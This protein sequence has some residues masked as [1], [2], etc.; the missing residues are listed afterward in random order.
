MDDAFWVLIAFIGLFAILY[1]PLKKGILNYLDSGIELYTQL[2]EESQNLC[3]KN[4]ELLALAQAKRNTAE[5]E[6]KKIIAH[7]QN[8]TQRIET[9]LQEQRTKL[10]DH[11]QSLIKKRY[12]LGL[13]EIQVQFYK[14]I[15]F[16]A[17]ETAKAI[18]LKQ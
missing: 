18:L 5:S 14:S 13:R 15:T 8:E 1:N 2:I 9:L 16:K 10:I 7:A 12:E 3:N 11:G 17:V 4:V 6:K